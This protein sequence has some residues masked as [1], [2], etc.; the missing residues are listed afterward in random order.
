MILL[1]DNYDSFVHNLARYVRELGSPTTVARNDQITLEDVQ[2]LAPAAVILS[3]GPCTPAEAGISV[4]LIEEFCG[5][6]PILGVCLGHQ[7]IGAAL[8]GTVIRAPEPVHGRTSWIR[9]AGTPLFAGVANPFQAARY[10][11][12][13]VDEATLP[14]ELKVTA[15]TTEG[16]PMA[17]ELAESRLFGL[18]FHPES[19]LTQFGHRLLANFLTLAGLT[20]LSEVSTDLRRTVR[21]TPVPLGPPVTPVAWPAPLQ[22]AAE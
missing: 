18:Q 16:V 14:A 22:E 3:P 15:R 2:R 5:K 9:H 7:A 20:S 11:S 4:P 12:L 21:A 6:I 8:G 17:L 10:H 13:I 19:V 1:I